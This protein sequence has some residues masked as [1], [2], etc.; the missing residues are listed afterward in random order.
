MRLPVR[1]DPG[2]AE[3]TSCGRDA[4]RERAGAHSSRTRG[5][6]RQDSR[7]ARRGDILDINPSTLRSRM[8]KLGIEAA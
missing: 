4:G 8:E 6:G 2:A 1:D 5:D 7:A 3:R